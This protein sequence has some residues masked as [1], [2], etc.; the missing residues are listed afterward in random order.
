MLGNLDSRR[1]W[2]FAPDYVEAMWR[3]VQQEQPDDYV[4]AT[5]ETHSVREFVAAAAHV[6]GMEIVWEGSG[7][8]E[9]GI[10]RRNGNRVVTIDPKPI[11]PAGSKYFG[12]FGEGPPRARLEPAHGFPRSWWKS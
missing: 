10:D 4:V 11:A 2:G 3:M 1:D 7:V 9:V 8:D 12:Q 5:G 6:A